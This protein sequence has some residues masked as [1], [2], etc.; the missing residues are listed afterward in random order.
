MSSSWP[1]MAGHNGEFDAKRMQNRVDRFIAGV[2]ALTERLV[3]ALAAQP[4]GFGDLRHAPR[5]RHITKRGKEN[6][7]IAVFERRRTVLGNSLVA[8]EVFGG[9][10][11]RLRRFL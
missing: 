10:Q 3:K 7:G 11:R 5:L 9:L 2:S 1:R 8:G 4:C 6:I